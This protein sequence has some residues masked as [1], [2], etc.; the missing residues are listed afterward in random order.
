MS[1]I[2]INPYTPAWGF[3]PATMAQAGII[4]GFHIPTRFPRAKMEVP[5]TLVLENENPG[6]SDPEKKQGEEFTLPLEPLVSISGKNNLI[7]RNI[8]F[9]DKKMHGTVKEKWSTDDWDITIAGILIADENHQLEDYLN[10][11]RKYT[12]ANRNIK[13]ICPYLNKGY[14][15]TRIVIESY[16]FPFTKGA[17]YQTYTLKCKSDD[18]EINLLI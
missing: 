5:V 10:G 1:T 2:T 13:I 17:D 4:R 11:L 12:E 16:D 6:E 14:G 8:A 15:I 18:S 7:C 9:N 3:N